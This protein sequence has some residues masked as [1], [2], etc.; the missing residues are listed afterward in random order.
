VSERAQLFVIDDHSLVRL[1]MRR[2]LD[3]EPDLRVCG[4]AADLQGALTQ[5]ATQPV[6]LVL[7]DLSLGSGDGLD[8]L[9]QLRAQRPDR[10][11]LVVTTHDERVYGERVVRGGAIG[12]V[13]KATPA[14]E[15]LAAIRKALRGELA[16]SPALASTLLSA[17][18]LG[19]KPAGQSQLANLSDRE[20]EI[21]KLVGEGLSTKDI[22]AALGISAKT[23]ETHQFNLRT[24]LGLA[25]THQ[26]RHIAF[27]YVTRGSLE[28]PS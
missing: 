1:G 23:V 7:L 18:V 14:D 19:H 13:M 20:L 3:S 12:Y 5:L 16:I 21:F 15:V 9:K 2:L 6:D 8:A 17:V 28:E 27:S 26:L 24:K 22:A 11:V 10:K 4:E 25:S